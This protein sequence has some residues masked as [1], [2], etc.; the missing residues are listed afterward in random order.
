MFLFAA[1]QLEGGYNPSLAA[2]YTYGK[3][4][5]RMIEWRPK[6]NRYPELSTVL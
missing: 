2:T 5:E 3:S 4:C 6:T 1:V